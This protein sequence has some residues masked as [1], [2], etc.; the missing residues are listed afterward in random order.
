M[1]SPRPAVVPAILVSL[2]PEAR[3]SRPVPT[4]PEVTLLSASV[5]L[6]EHRLED[7]SNTAILDRLFNTIGIHS[8]CSSCST[9]A[10]SVARAARVGNC[11]C[12]RTIRNVVSLVTRGVEHLPEHSVILL[13]R[14]CLQPCVGVHTE[15]ARCLVWSS[16]RSSCC[17]AVSLLIVFV[18]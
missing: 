4:V 10:T 7:L 1:G 18:A 13:I 11:V 9:T 5:E 6:Q 3:L 15:T 17:F 14:V 12:R 2:F 16:A 8:R